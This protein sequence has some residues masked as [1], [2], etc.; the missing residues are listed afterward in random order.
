MIMNEDFFDLKSMHSLECF[1]DSIWL[2][3]SLY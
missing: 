1:N 2:L 3:R